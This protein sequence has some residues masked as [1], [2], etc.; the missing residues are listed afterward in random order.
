MELTNRYAT[1]ASAAPAMLPPAPA[2]LPVPT[3]VVERKSLPFEISTEEIA[4][5]AAVEI[6]DIGHAP[7]LDEPAAWDALLDFLAGVP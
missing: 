3:P 6:P 1:A 4:E 2:L 7:M 5:A